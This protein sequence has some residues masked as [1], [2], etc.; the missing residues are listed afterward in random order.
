MKQSCQ[1]VEVNAGLEEEPGRINES[2]LEE[3]WIV[4]V[5]FDAPFDSSGLMDE[6]AYKKFLETCD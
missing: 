1:I 4:K 3:G 2:P 6:A 5:E